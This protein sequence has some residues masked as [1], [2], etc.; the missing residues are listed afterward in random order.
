MTATKTTAEV[1]PTPFRTRTRDEVA[2]LEDALHGLALRAVA[3]IE[4]ITIGDCDADTG[5]SS[6]PA[7]N[8]GPCPSCSKTCGSTPP[9]AAAGR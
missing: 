2:V 4:S 9:P 1:R 7:R 5:R 3:E 6:P 8:C